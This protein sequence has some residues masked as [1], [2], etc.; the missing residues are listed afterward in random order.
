[1][2]DEMLIS[3]KF[4]AIGIFPPSETSKHAQQSDTFAFRTRLMVIDETGGERKR[5]DSI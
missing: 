5:C 1:M 3:H 2:G 4:T